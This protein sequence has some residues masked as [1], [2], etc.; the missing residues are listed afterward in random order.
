MNTLPA[1]LILPLLLMLG[2][3]TTFW[4]C[5]STTV[6]PAIQEHIDKYKAID[7]TLI[8]GYLN[9]NHITNYT[10]TNSGL[11]LINDTN[12][13]GPFIKTGQLFA[14]KYIG[15]YLGYANNGRVFDNSYDSHSTTCQCVNFVA[16]QQIAGW[17]EAVLMMQKGTKKTLLIPS[18]LG[19]GYQGN[20]SIPGDQPLLF[21]M[22]IVDVQ[23]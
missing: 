10:R 3:S 11:Y 15:R 9:R 23:P 22:E 12:G 14:V 21:E 16:G 2:M 17:N 4:G 8:Q 5:T 13:S 18:Y 6:D 1:R 20:G 7:D 19:Y